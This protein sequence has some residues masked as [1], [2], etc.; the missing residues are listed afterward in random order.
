MKELY[1]NARGMQ[2]P[3]P[4]MQLHK[5]LKDAEPD[6]EV[7]IEVTDSGFKKD[8]QAWCKKTKNELV[9]LNEEDGVIIAKIKK[10]S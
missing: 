5:T 3:G 10:K 6:T 4:I 1:I 8:V 2:C 7:V 9:S